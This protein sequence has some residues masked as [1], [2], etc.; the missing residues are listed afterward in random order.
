VQ[1]RILFYCYSSPSSGYPYSQNKQIAMDDPRIASFLKYS[2]SDAASVLL[3]PEQRIELMPSR[4]DTPNLTLSLELQEL[5]ESKIAKRNSNSCLIFR[6]HR[7]ADGHDQPCSFY[8]SA[9]VDA[10]GS[11]GLVLLRHNADGELERL[12]FHLSHGGCMI[13]QSLGLR[14]PPNV[15]SSYRLVKACG[16]LQVLQKVG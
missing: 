11:T 5:S 2:P 13:R 8:W 9:T 14:V 4:P 7:G 1:V 12:K 15:Y 6:I 10:W 3:Q 16:F